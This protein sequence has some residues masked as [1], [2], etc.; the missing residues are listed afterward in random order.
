MVPRYRRGEP[1][2]GRHANKSGPSAT[3]IDQN[4]RMVGILSLGDISHAT[5]K[6]TAAEVARGISAHHA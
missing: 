4:K 6:R 1:S 3:V 5:S 2:G